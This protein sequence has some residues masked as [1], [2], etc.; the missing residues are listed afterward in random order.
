[1]VLVG[2]WESIFPPERNQQH[3]FRFMKQFGSNFQLYMVYMQGDNQITCKEKFSTGGSVGCSSLGQREIPTSWPRMAPTRVQGTSSFSFDKETRQSNGTSLQKHFLTLFYSDLPFQHHT[4]F[5]QVSFS[6]ACMRQDLFLYSESP[7]P[8]R[9]F[10]HFFF[11]F[12][13]V[14]PLH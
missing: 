7:S 10:L 6:R 3:T 11:F 1:M 2:F 4:Y 13:P 8:S 12:F 9:Y 5:D 14:A